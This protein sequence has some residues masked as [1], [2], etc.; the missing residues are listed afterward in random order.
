MERFQ[1]KPEEILMVD[2]MKL[3]CMM[4]QEVGIDTA[5]AAWSKKEFPALCK[6][7]ERLCDYTFRTAAA[8]EAFLF[9]N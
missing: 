8:L 1:L 6:E 3:G 4:A 2:D 7:M 9:E 5:F